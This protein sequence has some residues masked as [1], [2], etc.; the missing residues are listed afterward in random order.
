MRQCRQWEHL[1]QQKQRRYKKNIVAERRLVLVGYEDFDESMFSKSDICSFNGIKMNCP[2]V[3][4]F[5]NTEEV[6]YD[7]MI[8]VTDM[9]MFDKSKTKPI[10]DYYI[11]KIAEKSKK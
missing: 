9:Y 5:P 7:T 6:M 10:V 2:T 8:K 1:F 3:Q 4:I 11:K